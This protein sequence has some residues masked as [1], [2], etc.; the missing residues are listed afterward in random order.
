M[1]IQNEIREYSLSAIESF[2]KCCSQEIT[3]FLISEGGEGGGSGNGAELEGKYSNIISMAL[4]FTKF[5]PNYVGDDEFQVRSQVFDLDLYLY[6][7]L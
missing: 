6:L 7:Y 2:V 4:A 3:P 5:D 1:L